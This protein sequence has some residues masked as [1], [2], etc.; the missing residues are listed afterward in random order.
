MSLYF[1]SCSL[2]KLSILMIS[3]STKALNA[4]F[5]LIIPKLI[6]WGSSFSFTHTSSFPTDLC[7]WTCIG[8]IWIYILDSHGPQT[9]SSPCHCRH[10]KWYY[11]HVPKLRSLLNCSLTSL[12]FSPPS[13]ISHI[14]P[15]EPAWLVFT[16]VLSISTAAIGNVQSLKLLKVTPLLRLLRAYTWFPLVTE[17]CTFQGL[18]SPPWP[19]SK[20]CLT[21]SWVTLPHS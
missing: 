7:S 3:S 13:S 8:H 4:I 21:S 9:C 12:S 19:G 2:S 5:L 17:E 18:P 6:F 20:T 1:Q 11:K 16:T 15:N 10:R 14:R